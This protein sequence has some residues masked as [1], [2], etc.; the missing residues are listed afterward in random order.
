MSRWPGNY[1]INITPWSPRVGMGGCPYGCPP[2]DYDYYQNSVTRLL[3]RRFPEL[4]FT[5]AA[6]QF[7]ADGDTVAFNAVRIGESAYGSF[8]ESR[9]RRYQKLDFE[10][11]VAGDGVAAPHIAVDIV[12]AVTAV[13][14]R[15]AFLAAAVALQ[16]PTVDF[17]AGAGAMIRIIGKR[18]LHCADNC[19]GTGLDPTKTV[20]HWVR[21]S[22]PIVP[23]LATLG[24]RGL[25]MA[26][27][28]GGVGGVS[29]LLGEGALLY[30]NHRTT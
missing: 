15:D 30:G 19:S 11:D 12:A 5:F 4:Q 29:G 20:L 18:S 26:P 1:G 7:Y 8:V 21:T 28:Y 17:V 2:P 25:I 10:F 3:A 22:I 6:K 23:P 13:E 24:G 27:M 9:G 16:N 14:V